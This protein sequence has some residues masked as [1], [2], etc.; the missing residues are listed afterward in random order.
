MSLDEERR[1]NFIFLACCGVGA[2]VGIGVPIAVMFRRM[3]SP[4]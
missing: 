4:R 1:A 2:A 3:R